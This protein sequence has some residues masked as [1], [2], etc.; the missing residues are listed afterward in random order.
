M[1]GY[2]S[3][4]TVVR[5]RR[6]PGGPYSPSKPVD[7]QLEAATGSPAPSQDS[8]TR[9]VTSSG[10]LSPSTSIGHAGIGCWDWLAS[11]SL[12]QRMSLSTAISS[13]GCWLTSTT[14]SV[15]PTRSTRVVPTSNEASPTIAPTQSNRAAGGP[16]VVTGAGRA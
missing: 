6:S 15:P 12:D 16:P 1:Y 10:Q 11:R 2:Q 3:T 4:P 13:I 9:R 14:R 5:T 7:S 8:R